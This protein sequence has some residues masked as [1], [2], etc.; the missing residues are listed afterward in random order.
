M[1]MRSLEVRI[2][3]D[4]LNMFQSIYRTYCLLVTGKPLWVHAGAFLLL[5]NT[6]NQSDYR[7]SLQLWRD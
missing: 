2:T 6:S 4:V 1:I 3:K 5:W 7:R